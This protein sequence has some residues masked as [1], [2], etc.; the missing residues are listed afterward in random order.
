MLPGSFQQTLLAKFLS[1]TIQS[2]GNTIGVK[3]DGVPG[4]QFVFFHGTLPFL[5]QPYH[6]AGWLE[7]FQRVAAA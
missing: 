4:S 7:P 6:R 5:E 1:L 3:Q 2:F